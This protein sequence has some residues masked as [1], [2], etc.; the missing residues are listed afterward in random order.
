MDR[1][2]EVQTVIDQLCAW[3]DSN[4]LAGWDPYSLREHPLFLRFEGVQQSFPKKVIR[5][6]T[7]KII[8]CYPNKFLHLLKVPKKINAKGVG[9]FAD[10]YL[11]LYQKTYRDHYLEKAQQ[12]LH[13]LENNIS[14]GFNGACWGY[15]F[16]WHS[17]DFIPANTPS[18]VVTVTCGYAFLRAYQITGEDR[19]LDICDSI[20]SFILNDLKHQ[21]GTQEDEICLSYTPLYVEY[22]HNASLFGGDFLAQIGCIKKSQNL[23]SFA[24]RI[25]NYTIRRQQ[26]DGSFWYFGQDDPRRAQ[27]PEKSFTAVDHYH[28]GF[29]IRCLGS[30]ANLCQDKP[31]KKAWKLGVEYYLNHFFTT[32]GQPK[33]T[34][35]DLYPI[36]IHSCSEAILC[37]LSIIRKDEGMN[38]KAKLRLKQ[39][40]QYS[41]DKMFNPVEGYFMY[42]RIGERIIDVPYL[43]WG[44]AWMLLAL[45]EVLHEDQ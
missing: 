31:T 14:K 5:H 6:F 38:D 32:S 4:G 30:L 35:K 24:Q 29:V 41:V 34:P 21:P 7:H 25:A 11:I 19:Y 45:A 23:I 16:D 13:W 3:I 40:L 2:I 18:V 8:G 10:A 39:V 43:R 33:M 42:R 28:T 15:P 26:K 44:Q 36:D 27:I 22:V 9:L 12:C 17:L 20:V 37:L 1:N